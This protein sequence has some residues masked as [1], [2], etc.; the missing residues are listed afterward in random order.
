MASDLLAVG[1]NGHR[2]RVCVRLCVCVRHKECVQKYQH[3][4]QKT[5]MSIR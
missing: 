2:V 3:A 1:Y 4:V 5:L